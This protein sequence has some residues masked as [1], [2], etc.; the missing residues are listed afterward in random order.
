MNVNKIANWFR[1]RNAADMQVNEM[2][3][4]LTQLKLMKLLYL[5]QGVNLAAYDEPLF[6][7]PILAWKLGP[8]I[9][10][11]HQRFAGQHEVVG[12]ISDQDRSNY[13]E[14]EA[15]PEA[16]AVLNAVYDTYGDMSAAD[17][18]KLTHKQAPWI[19]TEQS[20]IMDLDTMKSYFKEHVLANEK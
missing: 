17:L 19:E 3:E 2:A 4:E 1:I 16:S 8:A 11:I 13:Q 14:I 7:E 15:I 20:H 6:S 18:V 5:A 12:S 9:E 10:I